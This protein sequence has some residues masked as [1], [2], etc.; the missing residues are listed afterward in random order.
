MT[1]KDDSI[2]GTIETLVKGLTK[3][4]REVKGRQRERLTD[5]R[6]AGHFATDNH[7][8]DIGNNDNTD[9]NDDNCDDGAAVCDC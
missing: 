2:D 7:D 6:G 5:V 4:R 8:Y 1:N 3:E 9:D